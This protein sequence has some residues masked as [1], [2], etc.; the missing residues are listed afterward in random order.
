MIDCDNYLVWAFRSTTS[1]P[2]AVMFKAEGCFSEDK[3]QTTDSKR[4]SSAAE[5]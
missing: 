5:G 3:K 4:N 2:G 1:M